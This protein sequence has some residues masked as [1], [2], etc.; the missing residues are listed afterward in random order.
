MTPADLSD[1]KAREEAK[2]ARVQGYVLDWKKIEAELTWAEAQLPAH[3][4]R[5]R[6]RTR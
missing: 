1:L 4:R 3:L 5:N 2:R 6:P